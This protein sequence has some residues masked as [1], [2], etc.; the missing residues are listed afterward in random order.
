MAKH[1]VDISGIQTSDIKVLTN[2]ENL[3]L[4]KK[5]KDNNDMNARNE[6]INGNLKLVL[7]I[8]KRFNH[9][10]ENLDDLFQVGCLGLVKAIDN[11]D[12]SYNVKLSTYAVPMILGEVKRYL[13]DNNSLRVSRSVKDLAYSVLKVKEELTNKLGRDITIEEIS[14]E[15]N[16][17]IVDIANSLDAMRTP[18][19]IF[20]PIYSDGGDTIYL[21]D[22]I[23][24]RDTSNKDLDVT[25]AVEDA[26]NNLDQRSR[27]IIEE[28][29]IIGKTQMEIASE[30]GIS[31]A[32]ISRLEK[33]AIKSLKKVLK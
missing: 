24:S 10:G 11:F 32:Q 23:T 29:Y 6:L 33:D 7:S 30:L 14:K 22:Q 17:D 5:Y 26:V 18:V 15:M 3:E 16:I 4:F 21:Y 2:E 13:R 8:I 28:R 12:I 27:K 1:K 19:S 31:Q 25:L 9:R 20:E